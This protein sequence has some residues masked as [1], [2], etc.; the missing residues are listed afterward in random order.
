MRWT[1][2]D[3]VARGGVV[4]PKA[5]IGGWRSSLR[6]REGTATGWGETEEGR[7]S[8]SKGGGSEKQLEANS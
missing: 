2:T 6:E 1:G 8:R 4:G 7:S 3:D 5:T